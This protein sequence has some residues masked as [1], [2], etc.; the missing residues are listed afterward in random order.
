MR[1]MRTSMRTTS[2]ARRRA[3]AT[4]STPSA[5]S[6]TI[7]MSG[8]ASRIVRSPRRTTAWSSA[9][10]TRI[11]RHG[12]RAALAGAGSTACTRQPRP[13]GLGPASSRP[14]TSA[15]RSRIPAM[16]LPR[17]AGPARRAPSSVD[18]DE[19]LA[20]GQVDRDGGPRRAGVARDVRQRLLDDPERRG[21]HVGGQR[22]VG[23]APQHAD[24]DARGAD[25]VEQRV[26]VGEPGSAGRRRR[27]R[28]RACRGPPRA[29]GPGRR[30][31]SARCARTSPAPPRGPRRP[32]SRPAPAWTAIALRSLPTTSWTSRAIRTRSR[33]A[34]SP[35][36]AARSCGQAAALVAHLR[37]QAAL[38][39][40]Q[41]G[42]Q[43]RHADH[44]DVGDEL[45]R[46]QRLPRRVGGGDRREHVADQRERRRARRRGGGR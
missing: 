13:S 43:E 7:S 34:A 5:A 23:R 18:V 20:V 6:P 9:S 12:A 28:R 11:G 27:R 3:R 29:S 16:P 21:L 25:G 15:A 14:P 1:G 26:E 39:A 37:E 42:E 4:A 10:R 8:S 24:L 17:P 36:S 38:L 2:A 44:A 30:A 32:A 31:P 33:A 41:V 45:E 40:Q 19:R 35:A 22:V 46:A